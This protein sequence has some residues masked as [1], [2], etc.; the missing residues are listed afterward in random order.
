MTGDTSMGTPAPGR[1]LVNADYASAFVLLSRAWDRHRVSAR[2][3]YF[4][5]TD[6]DQA[7][8][9]NNGEHGTALTLAYIFRPRERQRLTLELL[10]AVSYRPARTFIGSPVKAS[11]TQVQASYR[12]FF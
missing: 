6:K 3:E 1:S 2:A 10:H 7:A 12:F 11:E 5:T 8:V 4:E 9:D